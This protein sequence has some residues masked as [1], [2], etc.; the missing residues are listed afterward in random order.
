[1]T[2]PCVFRC[3]ICHNAI[4]KPYIS[5]VRRI[6]RH[7]AKTVQTLLAQEM[8]RYD[9]QDCRAL[10]EPHIVVQLQ[11]KTTYPS[12]GSIVPCSR[13]GSPVDRALP[14][15]SYAYV[16]EDLDVER[17]VATV[18]DETELAILCRDCEEP[19]EPAAEA[20]AEHEDQQERART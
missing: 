10:Q 15:I 12:S 6:E 14:C 7:T 1:M 17:L 3:S 13:C 4:G 18:I 19:D 20:V 2:K 9:S 8:F 16:E 11:L 5:L